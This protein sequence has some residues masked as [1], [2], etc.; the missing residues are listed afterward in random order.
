MKNS[1]RASQRVLRSW[2]GGCRHAARG[3]R[4][5]PHAGRRL[6]NLVECG[7]MGSS[8]LLSE[9]SLHSRARAAAWPDPRAA[10]AVP[11]FR[12]GSTGSGFQNAWLRLSRR[13]RRPLRAPLDVRNDGP[14]LARCV[15][16]DPLNGVDP[17]PNAS[18]H[19]LLKAFADLPG[20]P[21][22]EAG[23]GHDQDTKLIE[24]LL[25]DLRRTH[26]KSAVNTDRAGRR[27]RRSTSRV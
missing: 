19:P 27:A 25:N 14:E 16:V 18:A 23:R 7:P 20:K 6:G 21:V 13:R 9:L 11:P 12:A 15:A 8:A 17:Y 5:A 26:S 3:R 22:P 2:S 10:P 24:P 4:R 1:S